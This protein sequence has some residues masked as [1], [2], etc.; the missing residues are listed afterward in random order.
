METMNGRL[1]LKDNSGSVPELT[2]DGILWLDVEKLGEYACHHMTVDYSGKAVRDKV[3]EGELSS[4]RERLCLR[5]PVRQED[6]TPCG[7]FTHLELV[8][9]AMKKLFDMDFITVVTK[10]GDFKATTIVHSPA[11]VPA[12][13]IPGKR[14]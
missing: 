11:I 7:A 6:G 13:W 5:I 4:D 14:G 2:D 3:F 1:S 8:A 9:V 12:A 10:L